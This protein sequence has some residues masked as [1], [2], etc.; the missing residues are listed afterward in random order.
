V[1]ATLTLVKFFDMM[2][3]SLSCWWSSAPSSPWIR[4]F[5]AQNQTHGAIQVLLLNED[6]FLS[7]L[8]VRFPNELLIPKQNFRSSFAC[9]H[10]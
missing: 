2:G 10:F 7:K 4:S 5:L 9:Y 8:P 3:T 1:L 6:R